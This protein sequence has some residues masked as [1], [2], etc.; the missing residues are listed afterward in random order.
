MDNNNSFE[1]V[2]P[3]DNSNTTT[4][5]TNTTNTTNTKKAP[6]KRVRTIGKSTA[7]LTTNKNKHIK[8]KEPVKG[9]VRFTSKYINIVDKYLNKKLNKIGKGNT[10]EPEQAFNHLKSLNI[11]DTNIGS[12]HSLDDTPIGNLIYRKVKQHNKVA[13]NTLKAYTIWAAVTYKQKENDRTARTQ[14]AM[15]IKSY[16]SKHEFTAEFVEDKAREWMEKNWVSPVEFIGLDYENYD[17]PYIV[18]ELKN[19]DLED[20]ALYSFKQDVTEG[21]RLY[22]KFLPLFDGLVKDADD[23]LK[24]E[25]EDRCGEFSIY[26]TLSKAVMDHRI[27]KK[28]IDPDFINRFFKG[29]FTLKKI[30]K[31]FEMIGKVNV[32]IFD[33]VGTL[34]I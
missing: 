22:S 34:L 33:Q 30:Q 29:K 7:Y 12:L 8:I 23:D 32:R 17:Q 21:M 5:T 15:T 16:K 13:R 6:F 26:Y 1:I 28:Y 11:F 27:D 2:V 20:L 18:T 3:W 19:V 24:K 31:Y 10:I 9:G 4:T 14:R 25:F